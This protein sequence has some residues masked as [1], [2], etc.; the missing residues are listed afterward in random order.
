MVAQCHYE[1]LARQFSVIGAVKRDLARV[2]PQ[3]CPGGAAA[4]L[5]LLGRYGAM[6]MSRLAELLAVGMSMI[7]R[8]VAHV[9]DR[10]WIDRSAAP[11]ARFD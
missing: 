11:R 3:D 6:R 5:N 1:G 2:L 9:A 8:H 7:S 4:V 10:G